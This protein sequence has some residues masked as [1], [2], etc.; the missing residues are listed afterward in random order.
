MPLVAG[1]HKEVSSRSGSFFSGTT[2]LHNVLLVGREYPLCRAPMYL[3]HSLYRISGLG[4]SIRSGL[5]NV[6]LSRRVS[7]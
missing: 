1:R 3:L 4:C 2:T 6:L 5:G 7:V